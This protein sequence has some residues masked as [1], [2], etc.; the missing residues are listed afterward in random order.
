VSADPVRDEAERLVATAIAAVSMAARGLGGGGARPSVAN[1][2]PECCVCPVCRVIAAM[3]DPSPELSER[4]ASGA[5]DLAAGVT[6]LLRS[7][8]NRTGDTPPASGADDDFWSALRRQAQASTAGDDEDPWPAATAGSATT[9]GF[10]NGAPAPKPMAK[11][12]AKKAVKKAAPP[13]AA[14]KTAA[15]AKA[16][17][18]VTAAA[19]AKKVAKKVTKK[20]TKTAAKKA[21]PGRGDR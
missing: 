7:L 4:L 21:A 9:A 20:A 3:R 15:P 1:G 6:S 2:S 13:P 5:G 17:A 18:P 8:G 11:K 16:A 10:A 14:K 19:S 12:T